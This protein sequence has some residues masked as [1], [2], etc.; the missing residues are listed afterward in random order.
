VVLK[1]TVKI[2]IFIIHNR[3]A[4]KALLRYSL[5]QRLRLSKKAS[6]DKRGAKSA[7]NKSE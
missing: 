2:L 3:K 5:R 7:K 4:R 6:L 1:L